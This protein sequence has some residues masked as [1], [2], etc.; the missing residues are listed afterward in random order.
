MYLETD[1]KLLLLLLL[2]KSHLF[3]REYDWMVCVVLQVQGLKFSSV[4]TNYVTSLRS[5]DVTDN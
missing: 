3:D 2:F 4:V 1:F 5:E